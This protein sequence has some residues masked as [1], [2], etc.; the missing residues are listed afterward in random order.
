MLQSTKQSLCVFDLTEIQYCMIQYCHVVDLAVSA[1]RT[2]SDLVPNSAKLANTACTAVAQPPGTSV[3]RPRRLLAI[4]WLHDM[5]GLIFADRA[6]S[7]KPRILDWWV[8]DFKT[9]CFLLL[10]VHDVLLQW[11]K[12]GGGPTYKVSGLYLW[13]VGTWDVLA[14]HPITQNDK[15]GE[16]CGGTLAWWVHG[17]RAHQPSRHHSLAGAAHHAN[18]QFRCSTICQRPQPAAA[19]AC[20]H[21][22]TG[23]TMPCH[24]EPPCHNPTPCP[25]SAADPLRVW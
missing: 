3:V 15:G 2:D 11:L 21:A 23:N 1:I 6:G 22:V 13:S 24:A 25:C 18:C 19:A 10:Q 12:Q 4:V 5:D 14:V 9:A 8:S 17:K 16:C 20:M 7:F